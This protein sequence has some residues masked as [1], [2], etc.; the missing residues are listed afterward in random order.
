MGRL[1][2]VWSAAGALVVAVAVLLPAGPGRA[3]APDESR[4]LKYYEVR[5]PESLSA[6][7]DR[8]LDDPGR[9]DDIYHLNA[10]RTQPDGG[11]VTGAGQELKAG[12]VLVLP[13]DA[14]GDGI[15]YGVLPGSGASPSPSPGKPGPG[16]AA[17][18]ST[19]GGSDW[20]YVTLAPDEAW[21]R[22]TGEGVLVGV[23]DSGV[24]GDLP[25][26]AGRV[27]QGA[28]VTNGTSG[29]DVDCLGSG[30]G[31]AAIIAAR[32]DGSDG[33][34]SGV[35][36]GATILPVRV[37]ATSDVADP[38]VA[39]TGIQVAVSAGATVIALGSYVDVSDD[40]VAA[41]I[42]DAIDHDVVI[43]CPA[44]AGDEGAEAGPQRPGLLRVGGV[45][46]DE[47]PAESYLP[48]GVDVTAPGIDVRTYAPGGAGPRAGSGT[49]YA[50]A[51][52][53][54]TAALVRG[55]LPDL[56][57]EQVTRRIGSTA[58]PGAQA[59]RDDA[60]GF[61]MVNPRSAVMVTLAGEATPLSADGAPAAYRTAVLAV[62][63]VVLVAAVW[64]LVW[65]VRRFMTA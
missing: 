54:G 55:A 5:S 9:A 20:A 58:S 36:P 48:G 52:V 25:A 53:A 4:Y 42:T 19:G 14:T 6:L 47:Q 22:G 63:L 34:I 49:Q 60:T 33:S 11:R 26:L 8:F 38:A 3:A 29:G 37:V 2:R 65:R 50:V 13:W 43:V 15:R 31:M 45:G 35:A 16:C 44:P 62:V 51:F 40:A 12:W 61:G 28:D 41:A 18:A 10:D 46:P 7:A 32:A 1:S 30:T 23:V 27:P 56:T 17:I 59:P 21:A 39:A 64:L 24:D 57:A